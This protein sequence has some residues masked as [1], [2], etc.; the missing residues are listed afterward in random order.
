MGPKYVITSIFSRDGGE[1][2]NKK[3]MSG[4]GFEVRVRGMHLYIY[5]YGKLNNIYVYIYFILVP[6]LR[7]VVL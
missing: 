3:H 4:G 6:A 5:I 1:E 2:T 7:R